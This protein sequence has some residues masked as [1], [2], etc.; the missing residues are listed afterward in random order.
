M[1]S[2]PLAWAGAGMKGLSQALEEASWP[3]FAP[4]CLNYLIVYA[5]IPNNL[6]CLS[7]SP[8]PGESAGC[9]SEVSCTHQWQNPWR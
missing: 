3:P 5:L 8:F 6:V 2:K 7:V 1:G 9:L 4:L